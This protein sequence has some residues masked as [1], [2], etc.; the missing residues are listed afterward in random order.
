MPNQANHTHTH[1]HIIA[2]DERQR[3][4]L[5]GWICLS[6]QNN[7]F[8]RLRKRWWR[9]RRVKLILN[10]FCVC[11]LLLLL[12]CFIA[13]RHKSCWCHSLSMLVPLCRSCCRRRR[14]YV[15]EKLLSF[16]L[17]LLF[18]VCKL[19]QAI[20]FFVDDN[21]NWERKKKLFSDDHFLSNANLCSLFTLTRRKNI[22]WKVN[23]R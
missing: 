4:T 5:W 6:S 14:R 23:S 22:K 16:T 7:T 12:L 3:H 2:I 20:V 8:V 1:T 11:C 15:N 21:K 17:L 18:L 19:C 13:T 10:S 9:R